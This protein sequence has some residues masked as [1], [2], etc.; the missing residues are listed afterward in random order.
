MG[1]SV[2][3]ALGVVLE[4][5]CP[6]CRDWCRREIVKRPGIPAKGQSW[7]SPPKPAVPAR[8][9]DLFVC[10]NNEA[11]WHKNAMLYNDELQ[12]V[13]SPRLRALI[14]ADIEDALKQREG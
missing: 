4:L 1:Y 14:E 5:R 8:C 11:E 3:Y 10:P 2:S 13:R 9:F 7:F 12:R 6:I